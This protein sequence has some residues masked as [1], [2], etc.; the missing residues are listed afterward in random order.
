MPTV[1]NLIEYLLVNAQLDDEIEFTEFCW[2]NIIHN[3]KYEFSIDEKI[4]L[5]ESEEN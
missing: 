2:I 1:R 3:G 5:K 4:L